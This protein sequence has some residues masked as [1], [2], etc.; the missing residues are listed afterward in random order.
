ML[1][2]RE[3]PTIFVTVICY[4]INYNN[5]VPIMYFRN[6]FF[7]IFFCTKMRIYLFKI[8]NVIAMICMCPIKRCNH[9]ACHAKP[10]D[11]IKMIDD[12]SHTPTLEITVYI[13][14][15]RGEKTIYQNMVYSFL[16]HKLSSSNLRQISSILSFIMMVYTIIT[17]I[18]IKA[19]MPNI[20]AIIQK[21]VISIMFYLLRVKNTN[22]R[23]PQQAL[24]FFLFC[25][26]ATDCA[27][28]TSSLDVHF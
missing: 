13:L 11:I 25:G 5:H 2:I 27:T 3:Q 6:K 10:L 15:F 20:A 17:T 16:C 28:A 23:R 26:R 12:I 14:V 18:T 1:S 4:E 19:N 24:P 22:R 7:H 8:H 21:Q 9:N